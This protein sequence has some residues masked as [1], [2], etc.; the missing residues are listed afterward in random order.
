MKFLG[1]EWQKDTRAGTF[2][3]FLEAHESL[4][5]AAFLERVNRPHLLIGTELDMATWDQG[6]VVRLDSVRGSQDVTVG[7]SKEVDVLLN[8]PSISK[9]H[10]TFRQRDGRWG[11]VDLSSK[12]GT[13][14]DGKRLAPEV[15]AP[16]EGERPWIEIGPDVCAIFVT[17]ERLHEFL[18]QAKAS[19][20]MRP[21]PPHDP[22]SRLAWPTWSLL[23]DP[24]AP[25]SETQDNLPSELTPELGIPLPRKG[26][27][28][29]A[30][31]PKG[32]RSLFAT[33]K[34]KATTIAAAVVVLALVKIYGHTVAYLIFGNSHPGWFRK[35]E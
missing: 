2:R 4:D 5:R 34:R 10:A 26:R 31:E 23:Q 33:R 16:L 8:C 35:D 14:L 7:R 30:A 24:Q 19:R 12:H 22:R 29:A 17:P 28:T 32:L 25:G 20:G 21:P 6:I 9:R 18:T 15:F 3:R 13:T 1:G 27:M 11:I